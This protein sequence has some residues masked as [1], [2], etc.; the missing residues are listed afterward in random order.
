[1]N[2]IIQSSLFEQA[3]MYQNTVNSMLSRGIKN[4]AVLVLNEYAMECYLCGIIEGLTQ[5][6]IEDVYGRGNIPHDLYQLYNDCYKY[7]KE[8]LPPFDY[9]LRRDLKGA[10]KDYNTHRFPKEYSIEIDTDMINYDTAITEDIENIAEEYL[11]NLK[12][13]YNFQR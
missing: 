4:A 5:K 7:G 1:M 13:N 8:Y 12:N 10:F 2:Y 9:R 11:S 6:N 3:K